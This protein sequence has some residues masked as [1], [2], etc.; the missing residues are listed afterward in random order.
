MR[1]PGCAARS[2]RAR[3]GPLVSGRLTS[4]SSAPARLSASTVRA[5]A[6]SAASPATESPRASRSVR[7][8]RR[9]PGSSSTIRTATFTTPSVRRGGVAGPGQGPATRAGVSA[10]AL[11]TC[12]DRVD[13]AL[14]L[15][16]D[17]V[18]DPRLGDAGDDHGH[19]EQNAH[20][21]GGRLPAVL[22]S[23]L[24]QVLDEA[25]DADIGLDAVVSERVLR[26]GD[27]IG[28]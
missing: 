11:L 22:A 2:S 5:S 10:L 28:H 15:L 8:M 7:A 16:D 14:H 9:N 17:L 3:A 27:E 25:L 23:A 1:R 26:G 20:V 18:A 13:E 21:L 12:R 4:S 19:D 24:D 6:A